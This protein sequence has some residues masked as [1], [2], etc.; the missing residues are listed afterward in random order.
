M[1][2]EE[3][4]EEEEGQRVS[5]PRLSTVGMILVPLHLCAATISQRA[6]ARARIGIDPLQLFT[7]HLV[8]RHQQQHHDI[9]FEE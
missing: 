2:M 7:G 1:D 5:P 8:R 4:E 6:R 9:L 3:K